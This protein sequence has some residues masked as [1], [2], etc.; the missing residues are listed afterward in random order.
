MVLRVL[1][2]LATT[3]LQLLRVLIFCWVCWQHQRLK[4]TE[5]KKTVWAS[6]GWP[7][8]PST[9]HRPTKTKPQMS[10]APH[11]P[12]RHFFFCFFFFSFQRWVAEELLSPPTPPTA[13]QRFFGAKW[14]K[15]PPRRL[16]YD[17]TQMSSLRPESTPLWRG[18]RGIFF[19]FGRSCCRVCQ[20][21]KKKKSNGYLFDFRRIH[22]YFLFCRTNSVRDLIFV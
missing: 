1:P 11:P 9:H 19:L 17:K 16:S 12:P 15:T 18:E 4:K 5:N 7:N 20:A 14:G 13:K 2:T 6:K 8:A 10:Y 21:K 22:I 3:H